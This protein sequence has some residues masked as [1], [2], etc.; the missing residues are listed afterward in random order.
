MTQRYKFQIPIG[1]WSNDG[2]GRCDYFMADAAKPF[3]EVCKA[4]A[5]ARKLWKLPN[6]DN[7]SVEQICSEYEE[8]GPEPEQVE[9][10]KSKGYICDPDDF[11]ARDMADLVVWFL[12]K[13]DPDLDVHL[14]SDDVPRLDNHQYCH[15]MGT[16]TA[17]E[18]NLGQFGY[19]LFGD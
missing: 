17:G 7:F 4:F 12:N 5:N 9:F 16:N 11:F 8:W 1:D 15:H 18:D 13:G 14:I 10:L 6:G 3:L 19:G 2:H